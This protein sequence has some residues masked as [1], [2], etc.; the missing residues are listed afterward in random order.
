MTAKI[1]GD[2]SIRILAENL[3]EGNK[4]GALSTIRSRLNGEFQNNYQ[5]LV[6]EGWK[7]ALEREEPSS[8]IFQLLNGL[9]ND[10]AKIS[11]QDIKKKKNEILIRDHTQTTLS[12]YYITTW[13]SLLEI[14]CNI[15]QEK[16]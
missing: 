1:S 7:R 2:S 15:C 16:Q 6:W 14:Y 8:L 13:V 12:K 11:Y 9:D 3:S 5:Q 10:Q 4:K